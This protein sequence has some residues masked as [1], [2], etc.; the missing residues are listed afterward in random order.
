[1]NPVFQFQSDRDYWIHSQRQ[2]SKKERCLLYYHV[3]YC[4][5]FSSILILEIIRKFIHRS[6]VDSH[7]MG[8]PALNIQ[9][10]VCL[11]CKIIN[12]MQ[13]WTCS[14]FSL[15]LL[16]TVTGQKMRTAAARTT[17]IRVPSFIS[18][19]GWAISAK[20]VMSVG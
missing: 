9:R 10:T 15:L 1:M 3:P 14:S 12:A 6:T 20:P 16:T 18:R 8:K 4:Y 5:N 13:I 11:W 19:I 17:T 7:I 2:T